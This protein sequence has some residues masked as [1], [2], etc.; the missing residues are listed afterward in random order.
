MA[1][2]CS[3]IIRWSY[4]RGLALTVVVLLGLCALLELLV[5]VV[6][7]Q[8]VSVVSGVV[9]DPESANVETLTANDTW[10]AGACSCPARR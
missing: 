3:V 2:Y 5:P 4:V 1:R 10:Y 7:I 6:S 8:R 9:D